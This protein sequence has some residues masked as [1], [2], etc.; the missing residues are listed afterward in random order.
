MLLKGI[1]DD[2]DIQGHSS[3]KGDN[4]QLPQRTHK[5][6]DSKDKD[7][8]SHTEDQKITQEPEGI[9]PVSCSNSS[10]FGSSWLKLFKV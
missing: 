7:N 3:H 8:S 10:T 2:N 4:V 1:L 9:S 5:I 6:S